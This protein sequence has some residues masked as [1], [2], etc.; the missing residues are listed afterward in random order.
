MISS[1]FQHHCQIQSMHV[2]CSKSEDISTKA[3][4]LP[5]STSTPFL[6]SLLYVSYTNRL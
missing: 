4:V 1:K 3:S 2:P 5:V 6:I